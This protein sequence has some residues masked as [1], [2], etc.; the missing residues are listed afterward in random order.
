M[1]ISV[2]IPVY[3]VE[4]TLKRAVYSV[5][6]QTYNDIEIIL[7]NDGSTDNSGE[8]C[9]K[10]KDIDS[11]IKVVHKVNGG[12]SSARNAGIEV[13]QGE[14]LSFLDSDDEFVDDIFESFIQSYKLEKP[15][16]YIFNLIRVVN[17]IHDQKDSVDNVLV[18]PEDV[19]KSLLTYSGVNFYTWNKI[20]KKNLFKNTAFPLDTL[21]EDT[22]VSYLT[23]SKASKVVI[24]S[25]VGIYYYD[26]PDSIVAQTFN[27]KQMHNVTER[28][29][30]HQLIKKEF[31]TLVS[32]SSLHLMNGV[33]STA[34]KIGSSTNE[35][36][37]EYGEKLIDIVKNH[38][39][40]FK[41]S[42]QIDWRR[43]V[44]WGLFKINRKLYAIMYKKYLNK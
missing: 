30:M 28:I 34:Y 35:Q 26:N 40:D 4:K 27:P 31:P 44:A 43:K 20:Y 23:A 7:V 6:N 13:A 22:V 21:Y 2:I 36:S 37:W 33:L 42:D 8:I 18:D 39:K 1:L 38:Q 5:I 3:N 10:L 19:V 25:K 17:D 12:L 15:E 11:R 32:Y 14:Y 41:N 16:M 9:N 24:T 29:R